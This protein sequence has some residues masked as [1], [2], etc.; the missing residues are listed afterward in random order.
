LFRFLAG[1]EEFFF[2]VARP[3]RLWS[4][5][6]LSV[7][8]I[9]AAVS[10][11]VKRPESQAALNFEVKADWSYISTYLYAFVVFT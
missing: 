3:D 10:P 6:Q 9:M 7:Q 5:T 2:S 11:G 8:R 4:H 1:T